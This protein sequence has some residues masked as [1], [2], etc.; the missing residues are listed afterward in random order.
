M[1][2]KNIFL[3]M[4]FLL[5]TEFLHAYDVGWYPIKS[6]CCGNDNNNRISVIEDSKRSMFY[7]GV[8][9]GVGGMEVSNF[10]SKHWY[11]YWSE[12]VSRGRSYKDAMNFASKR[13]DK[14]ISCD[15]FFEFQGESSKATMWL[16]DLKNKKT[17]G[18]L[19]VNAGVEQS[20][21]KIYTVGE[22]GGEEGCLIM[23][24]NS[25]WNVF[26][27]DYQKKQSCNCEEREGKDF[28][29][30]QVHMWRRKGLTAMKISNLLF[31]LACEEGQFKDPRC[32]NFFIIVVFLDKKDFTDEGIGKAY[33]LKKPVKCF[34][35]K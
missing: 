18:N 12:E 7:L 3:I 23:A 33:S 2:M 24:T 27:K 6:K 9:E 21:A 20:L 26:Y 28:I 25:F 13:C 15:Y 16:I 4:F 19:V 31:D 11:L 22:G 17:L 8:F 10:L 29:E 14:E 1:A 5:G 30:E 34:G 32:V 35:K